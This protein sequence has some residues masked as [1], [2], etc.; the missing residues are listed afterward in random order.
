M[1]SPSSLLKLPSETEGEGEGMKGR[2]LLVS[3]QATFIRMG[4]VL[5][6]VCFLLFLADSG[7][8]IMYSLMLE[9]LTVLELEGCV[10]T[11]LAAQSS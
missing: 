5:I 3:V 1:P 4:F 10:L 7:L 6:V 2:G 8:V 9:L 11:V